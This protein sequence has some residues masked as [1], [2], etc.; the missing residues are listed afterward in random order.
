MYQYC[1]TQYTDDSQAL[2]IADTVTV[3]T[4]RTILAVSLGDKN[5]AVRFDAL[6][7]NSNT[8][9]GFRMR[10][11]SHDGNL[12]FDVFWCFGILK[13]GDRCCSS[14][15]KAMEPLCSGI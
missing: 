4:V 11:A 8:A 9:F 6:L 1:G 5:Y 7:E 12:G 2:Y 14:H 10:R 3:E 13:N 15:S